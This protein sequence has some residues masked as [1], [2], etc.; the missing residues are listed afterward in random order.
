MVTGVPEGEL[1]RT[2]GHGDG[3][4]DG[5]FQFSSRTELKC[6]V[7]GHKSGPPVETAKNLF[8]PIKDMTGRIFPNLSASLAEIFLVEARE[9]D[10]DSDSSR[11]PR[12]RRRRYQRGWCGGF[13]WCQNRHPLALRR[14]RQTSSLTR[15]KRAGLAVAAQLSS[16]PFSVAGTGWVGQSNDIGR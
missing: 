1:R 12:A 13:L 4:I 15:G 2:G 6:V 9:T 3:L 8:V 7:C 16:L 14:H 10:C 5:L 11:A